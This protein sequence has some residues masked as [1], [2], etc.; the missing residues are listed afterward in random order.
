[1]PREVVDFDK[2]QAKYENGLLHLIIPKKEEA[3]P[4]PP[5]MINIS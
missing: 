3:K 5:K 2:I 1:L 4:K